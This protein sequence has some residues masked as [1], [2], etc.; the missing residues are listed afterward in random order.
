MLLSIVFSTVSV[1]YS[2]SDE[3]GTAGPFDVYDALETSEIRVFLPHKNTSNA[4]VFHEVK[5]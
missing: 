5:A 4:G 2:P 3:R 1:N